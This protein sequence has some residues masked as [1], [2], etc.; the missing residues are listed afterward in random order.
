MLMFFLSKTLF[1]LEI[2]IKSEIE[3]IVE[4]KYWKID[5]TKLIL[6]SVS[7]SYAKLDSSDIMYSFVTKNYNYAYTLLCYALRSKPEDLQL[8]NL[9]EIKSI[10][11][12][13]KQ[14]VVKA[15]SECNEYTNA[16]KYYLHQKGGIVSDFKISNVSIDDMIDIAS[17]YYFVYKIT[18]EQKIQFSFCGGGGNPYTLIPELSKNIIAE[19]FAFQALIR[20]INKQDWSLIEKMEKEI[21][22]KLYDIISHMDSTIKTDEKLKLLRQITW[23]EMKEDEKIR[24]LIN[25][26]YTISKDII[27]ITIE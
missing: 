16:I 24:N 7:P 26:E 10:L 4:I 27:P 8:R 2:N 6:H 20:P 25:E 9:D 18:P 1:A 22:P 19:A 17:K 23:N 13:K 21:K 3:R 11:A 15:L 14:E 5:S 12:N